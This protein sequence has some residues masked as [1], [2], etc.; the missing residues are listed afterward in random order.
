MG[1]PDDIEARVARDIAEYGWHVVKVMGD[2]EAPGW[3]YTIGLHERLAHP[4]LAVFGMELEPMHQVLNHVAA[5]VGTGRRFE[6]GEHEGVFEGLPCALRP[7]APRWLP[8]FFGNAEWHYKGRPFSILQLFWPDAGGRFP[9]E[10]GFA[11]SWRVRQPLLFHPQIAEALDA[12]LAQTLRREGALDDEAETRP[13][14]T[15]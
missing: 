7:V 10:P 6:P 4:E 2:D 5:L 14:A 3:A 9:W 11:A 12:R 13:N 1:A 15:P 8:V